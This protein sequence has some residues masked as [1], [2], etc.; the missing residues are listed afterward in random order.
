VEIPG[1]EKAP[2]EAQLVTG[3]NMTNA[4]F[5][6]FEKLLT[7]GSKDNIWALIEGKPCKWENNQWV[8]KDRMKNPNEKGIFSTY[9]KYAHFS[10][11][12][13]LDGSVY[14]GAPDASRN[15]FIIY[16]W[17]GSAWNKIIEFGKAYVGTMDTIGKNN[18]V[19]LTESTENG[20]QIYSVYQGNGKEWKVLS[21]S[22]KDFNSPRTNIHAG[23]DGT[24]YGDVF[25]ITKE[26]SLVHEISR[27]NGKQWELVTTPQFDTKN[28]PQKNLIIDKKI[29][30]GNKN[31]IWLTQI[32]TFRGETSEEL[33]SY[34]K[35][36]GDRIHHIYKYNTKENQFKEIPNEIGTSE[37]Y[38]GKDGI[39]TWATSRDGKFYQWVKE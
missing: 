4:I 6:I 19:L 15:R 28:I 13:N 14:I 3:M 7:I 25:F 5:N 12:A 37:I 10:I 20:R 29:S 9:A 39:T 24:L 31:N 17:N 34:G 22:N 21:N 32:F 11:H 2:K 18:F 16:E 8:V 26:N 30:V 23:S 35:L 38:A 33:A 36:A 1:A 27:W